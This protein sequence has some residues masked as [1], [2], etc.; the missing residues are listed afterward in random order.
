MAVVW[1]PQTLD[2]FERIHAHNLE[3]KG[4]DRT[5][6]IESGI[7]Q[8]GCALTK[9]SGLPWGRP[10]ERRSLTRDNY[11]IFFR[12]FGGDIQIFAIF[13]AKEDWTV[14]TGRR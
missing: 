6:Q 10:D 9:N 5:E 2:D 14:L 13:H 3:W 8:H 1:A 11:W 12:I 7:R 4:P